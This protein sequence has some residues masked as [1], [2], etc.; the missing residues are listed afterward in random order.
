[1]K[2]MDIVKRMY[3]MIISIKKYKLI[4]KKWIIKKLDVI[5][6]FYDNFVNIKIWS[7]LTKSYFAQLWN[8]IMG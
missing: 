5:T 7:R 1:M 8:V 6:L 2:I 4:K 3:K